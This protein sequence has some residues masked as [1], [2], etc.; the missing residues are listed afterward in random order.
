MTFGCLMSSLRT[1]AMTTKRRRRLGMFISALKVKIVRRFRFFFIFSVFGDDFQGHE[2]FS[3]SLV[4]FRRVGRKFLLNNRKRR[5]NLEKDRHFRWRKA[6][7]TAKHRLDGVVNDV[8][9]HGGDYGNFAFPPSAER[10]I[11][12]FFRMARGR[13]REKKM[14]AK[15]GEHL[16]SPL[17]RTQNTHKM[18]TTEHW[19]QSCANKSRKY[20]VTLGEM[21]RML[22]MRRPKSHQKS[23]PMKSAR[24]DYQRRSKRASLAGRD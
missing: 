22:P 2:S 14:K 17:A 23:M 6:T 15:R 10:V 9:C 21:R 1:F 11:L 4:L 3:S 7:K 18:G 8:E 13:R 20:Y 16:S 24:R 12:M 19:I 5:E